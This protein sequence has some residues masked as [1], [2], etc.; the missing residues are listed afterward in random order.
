[1]AHRVAHVQDGILE[2]DTVDVENDLDQLVD[3]L[4]G[5]L[6]PLA[7]QHLTKTRQPHHGEPVLLRAVDGPVLELGI[8]SR[9]DDD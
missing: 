9:F 4:S 7:R 1:M 5:S 3:L 8:S 2:P 6:L